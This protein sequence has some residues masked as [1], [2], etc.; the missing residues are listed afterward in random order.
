L[1]L[2]VCLGFPNLA[3]YFGGYLNYS[4]YKNYGMGN[5]FMIDAITC[6][7]SLIFGIKLIN[8]DNLMKE[9]ENELLEQN[10]I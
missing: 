7:V 9:E 6:I 3:S 5:A 4:A 1:A 10:E 2:G 8:L